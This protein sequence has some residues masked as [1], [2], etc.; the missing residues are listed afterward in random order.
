MLPFLSSEFGNSSAL[1]DSG[2]TAR[3]VV[4]NARAE[5]AQLLEAT[6][7]ELIFTS[8]GTEANNLAVKGLALAYQ[9]K[10]RHILTTAI[11][12]VSVLNAARALEQFGFTLELVPVDNRGLVDPAEVR[13]RLRPDTVLVSVMTANNE[14]GTIEPVAE[15]ARLTRE[16]GIILHTDA[17]C[18]AGNIPLS[19]HELGVDAMSLAGNQFYG[20]GGTGALWLRSGLNLVPLL[21]GGFQENRKR[22]GTENVAGVVGL[23]KAAEI[24]RKNLEARASR[25]ITL[26][27]RLLIELPGLIPHM[28]PTGDLARRLPGHA[29]FCVEFVEGEAMLLWLN[30]KGIAASTVSSCTSKALRA[31]HVLLA[32]GLTHSQSQGS[33]TFSLG[34]SNTTDD[35]DYV[36]AVMPEIVTNLRAMSPLYAKYL[37]GVA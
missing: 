23:G 33:L 24:A 12:H 13:R 22:A 14:V 27:D 30:S 3:D 36:L 5:V 7:G 9:S 32:M 35:V 2:Q 1:H 26:R 29:S 8:N 34:H 20:P 6:P 18:A 28:F 15:I 11:E 4:E 21:D 31:S 10:G 16:R 17:V 37:K 19:V 25:L